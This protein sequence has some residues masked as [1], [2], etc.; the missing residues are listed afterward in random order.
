MLSGNNP[1][2]G[3]LNGQ[4][5]TTAPNPYAVKPAWDPNGMFSFL[6]DPANQALVSGVGNALIA[7]SQGNDAAVFPAFQ[8][9][10]GTAQQKQRN[11]LIAQAMS[12]P[13]AIKD[14]DARK[15]LALYMINSDNK[16][17]QTTGF[18]LLF[19]DGENKPVSVSAGGTLV[20]PKTGK[21]IYQAPASPTQTSLADYRNQRLTMN[22]WTSLPTDNKKSLLAQARAMGYD[23]NDAARLFSQGKSIEDL[24]KDKGLDPNNLPD[25]DYAPTGSVVA[26]TQKRNQSLSEINKLNPILTSAIEPYSRRINGYSPA[27]IAGAISGDDP[28]KQA[29]FLAARALMPEMSALRAKAMG[30]SIGI[31]ALREIQNSSMGNIKVFGSLVSPEVYSKANSY[32]D[33]WLEQAVT[34][35]NKVALG[36]KNQ[37]QSSSGETTATVGGVTYVKRGSQWFP[38]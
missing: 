34:A 10:V 6:N 12:D 15:Q 7:K 18:K 38:Q 4:T 26:N 13:N 32:I 28:D 21:I 36:S 31:E 22:Q 14:P 11:D 16:D 24:A 33:Q 2:Y 37:D 25:P 27:Q 19:G 30:A 3:I 23:D 1:N 35:S 17:L 8:N 5:P 29:K 20:D 9:A